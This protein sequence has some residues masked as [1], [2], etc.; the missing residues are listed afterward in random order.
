LNKYI[1]KSG[2]KFFT[3]AREF[4]KLIQCFRLKVVTALIETKIA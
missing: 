4:G 1:I 3:G 2:E